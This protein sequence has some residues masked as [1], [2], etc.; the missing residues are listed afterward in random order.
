MF[1]RSW[2]CGSISTRCEWWLARSALSLA[3]IGIGSTSYPCTF[4]QMHVAIFWNLLISSSMTCEIISCISYDLIG[5]R[6]INLKR[7]SSQLFC[8]KTKQV[9]I[10]K[11]TQIV[12]V[13]YQI[14]RHVL[15]L[16]F[17]CQDIP[18]FA[19]M[20]GLWYR[21]MEWF[22]IICCTLTVGLYFG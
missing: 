19:I 11:A 10:T 17:I 5:I 9:V 12:N 7:G 8:R 3:L 16:L 15:Q 4:C 20:T 1:G 13:A 18:L 6:L 21:H 14:I 22:N 2:L